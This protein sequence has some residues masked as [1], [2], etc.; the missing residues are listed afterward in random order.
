MKTHLSKLK[1]LVIGLLLAATAS[2]I[3][4]DSQWVEPSGSQQI[5]EGVP[6]GNVD[7]PI[8]VSN[9]TQDKIGT[10]RTFGFKSFGP[11][12]IASST[13]D[14]AYT[15]TNGLLFGVNGKVGATEYCDESGQNC[16][17][18]TGGLSVPAGTVAAFNL[19]TCPAGWIPAD[20]TNGTR[21][22]RGVFIRGY[23]T[24]TDGTAA[25]GAFGVFQDDA[26][27][28]HTHTISNFRIQSI[29]G[30]GGNDIWDKDSGSVTTS[31]V[32]DPAETRPDN[33]ALLFCQK[34]S[35]SSGGGSSS[36]EMAAFKSAN[37]ISNFPTYIS[38][39]KSG[40]IYAFKLSAIENN[41]IS[42]WAWTDGVASYN[43]DGTNYNPGGYG[44]ACP[45]SI[46]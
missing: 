14:T 34:D 44:Y 45:S 16:S 37:D 29:G 4:A 25:S 11:A 46:L 26:F 8:N 32:G 15:L 27:K 17:S 41:R 3:N 28:A 33:V 13:T 19:A 30:G 42:Y 2:Y 12:I 9:V 10:L 40:N 43:R 21:D 20:G 23:G 1:F 22:L 5:V 36:D 35:T 24:N 38:C 6:A 18:S 7:T 39:T 31:S